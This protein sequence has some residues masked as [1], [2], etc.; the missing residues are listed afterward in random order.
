[1]AAGDFEGSH[2]ISTG[3]KVNLLEA[4]WVKARVWLDGVG[5]GPVLK[6]VW[7]FQERVQDFVMGRGELVV[8]VPD[9]PSLMGNGESRGNRVE[10]CGDQNVPVE[11]GEVVHFFVEGFSPGEDQ[12]LVFLVPSNMLG[13]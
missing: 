2:G 4:G 7:V 11:F 8:A 12:F 9:R 13:M 1:M 6:S 10:V 5:G 3:I